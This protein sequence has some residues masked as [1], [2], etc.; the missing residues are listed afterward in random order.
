[1]LL[2]LS[3]SPITVGRADDRVQREFT[4]LIG[5]AGTPLLDLIDAKGD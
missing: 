4:D 2:N 1:M 5:F 3:S